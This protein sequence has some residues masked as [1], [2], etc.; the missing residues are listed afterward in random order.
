MRTG[1]I[2]VRFDCPTFLA[3]V[4]RLVTLSFLKLGEFVQIRARYLYINPDSIFTTMF[5]LL[6][7]SNVSSSSSSIHT[8]YTSS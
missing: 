1:G 6:N 7:R 8:P 4:R 2:L 5:V 3:G